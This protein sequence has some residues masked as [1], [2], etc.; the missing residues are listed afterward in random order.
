MSSVHKEREIFIEESGMWF[1]PYSW[2]TFFHVEKS[3]VQLSHNP[4]P[5]VEFIHLI[6]EGDKFNLE[7]VE[8]KR[9]AP[10]VISNCPLNERLSER[11][12]IKGFDKKCTL[13]KKAFENFINSIHTKFVGSVTLIMGHIYHRHPQYSDELPP[14]FFALNF[15]NICRIKCVLVIN[16]HKED[17]LEPIQRTLKMRLLAFFHLWGL[18]QYLDVAVLNKEMAI[19]R[20]LVNPSPL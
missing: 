2:E 11:E 3:R 14:D 7:F 18:K 8:A 20:K 19:K 16:G 4:H 1:G 15:T 6:R 13:R 5:M 10:Q 9:S 17:W 12:V